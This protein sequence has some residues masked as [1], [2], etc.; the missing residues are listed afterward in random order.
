MRES[1]ACCPTIL[2]STR[3]L[4]AAAAAVGIG[5]AGAASAKAAM[6]KET[7][8]LPTLDGYTS[9][10]GSPFSAFDPVLGTLNSVTYDFIW[11]TDFTG[12]GLS[13]HNFAVY[14]F[15][16]LGPSG[17]VSSQLG[18]VGT[19]GPG[20]RD[21]SLQLT[22]DPPNISAFPG[23]GSVVPSVSVVNKLNSPATIVSTFATESVTY[24]YTPAV[25][26]PEASTWAMMLIGFAGLGAAAY[27]RRAAAI[28][29]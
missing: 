3:S 27:R 6:I 18:T 13:D 11:T 1:L 2:R 12:G 29:A 23:P 8:T 20:S 9:E 5:L 26:V 17:K 19:I 15:S 22:I 24:N 25:I 16:F 4:L 10:K 7:F 28:L 14:T 21:S